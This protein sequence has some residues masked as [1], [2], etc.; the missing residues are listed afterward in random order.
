MMNDTVNVCTQSVRVRFA[1]SPTGHL[2]IGGLRTAF[3]NMLFARHA[4]GSFLLRIEDTDINRSK[5]EYTKAIFEALSW[6]QLVPDEP[7]VIQSERISQHKAV[8]E[9]LLKSGKAYKCYC[10]KNQSTVEVQ[11]SSEATDLF[12]KYDGHCRTLINPPFADAPYVIRFKLPDVAEF[13]FDD[14]IRGR[15][16]FSIDQFEDFVLA[17]SDGLP[18][19]NFVVV[20]DDAFMDITHVI[21]GEEHLINTPKQLLLYEACGFNAPQFAHLPL[22]LGKNGNKLSKRDAAT[23]VLDY[24]QEGYLPDALLNYLVRLGW[25][26]GDQEKFT[27]EEL[28][29]FFSLEE[30][31]KKGAIFSIEKLQWLNSEYIREL[32]ADKIFMH[33]T[34]IEADIEKKLFLWNRDLIVHLINLYKTRIVTLRELI[35]TLQLLHDGPFQSERDTKK[36]GMKQLNPLMMLHAKQIIS[37]VQDSD[38]FD[39]HTIAAGVKKL[40]KETGV[41]L[42]IYTQTIRITLAGSPDGPGAFELMALV[43][44]VQT[45]QRLS[46]LITLLSS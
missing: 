7:A 10:I 16:T 32:T 31:G 40:A 6:T 46:T 19:Y 18:M 3:F 11:D 30:V 27:R 26:H 38:Q 42:M 9:E 29:N 35:N 33:C 36:E 17:R 23:S 44:K 37:V 13:V 21:R 41:P 1:P 8:L 5:S 15:M 28:I 34:T 22:I 14:L 4:G 25:S 2:H 12:T 20:V 45:I 39:Q 24:K 43:G